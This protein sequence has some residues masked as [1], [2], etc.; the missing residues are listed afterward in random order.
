MEAVTV[1]EALTRAARRLAGAGVPSP[2]ADARLLLGHI[3]GRKPLELILDGNRRLTPPEQDGFAALLEARVARR[4]LQHLVGDVEFYGRTFRVVPGVLVPRPETE[5]VVEAA[6]AVLDAAAPHV[7]L[8]RIA[9][10]GSGAGVIGL[11]LAAERPPVQVCCIDRDAA[12]A[13]LTSRNAMELGIAGRVQVVRGDGVGPLA[14]GGFDLLVSNPPYLPSALIPKLEPEVRNHDPRLALDGGPDGL[15]VIR[16]LL[17]EAG[18]VLRP[19]GHLVIE[20]GHDQGQ[21]A[22]RLAAEVGWQEV[23]LR[24]DLAGFDRVLAA[25]RSA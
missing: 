18:P 24:P 11:T 10:I 13:A 1:A 17:V 16:R 22:T 19:G 9:D 7:P 25:R 21:V 6:L 23:H 8:A 3:L 20:I 2:E 4:P 15:E 14:R 12:A 5:T